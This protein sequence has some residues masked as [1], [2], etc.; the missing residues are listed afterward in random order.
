MYVSDAGEVFTQLA[1]IQHHDISDIDPA[2]FGFETLV[3]YE[4]QDS[5]PVYYD[6][7]FQMRSTKDNFAECFVQL[8]S[9]LGHLIKSVDAC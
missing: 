5:K 1:Y 2:N 4:L 6:G 9:Q 8:V 3:K 7:E